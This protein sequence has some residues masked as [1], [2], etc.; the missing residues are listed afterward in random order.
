MLSTRSPR[1]AALATLPWPLFVAT[2]VLVALVWLTG[3]GAGQL[4]DPGFAPWL[5]GAEL[6]AALASLSRALDA[7]WITLGAVNVYLALVR[8]EGLAVARRWGAIVLGASIGIAAL[9]VAT[10]LPLGPVHFT[11]GLG[12]KIGPVPFALPFLWLLVVAGAREVVWRAL[13]RLG[14]GPTAALT[15]LLCGL[16]S[17]LFDP[18]AW[19]V[20]AWWLWYPAQF[21][22]PASTPWTAH[23]TWL[24]AGAALAFL[25]RPEHVVPR[26]I[27]RP[28][29]PLA[30]FLTLLA[31]VA[32]AQVS[33]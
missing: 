16:S 30:C 31:L 15:G 11:T 21:H 13:P 4:A 2:S 12:V 22:A 1:L 5:R 32:L 10:A 27:R 14:H 23:A 29:E 7:A 25:L 20:R 3:F 6:R 19:K 33:R 24:A 8:T 9:S 26:T 18:V 17:V 28:V